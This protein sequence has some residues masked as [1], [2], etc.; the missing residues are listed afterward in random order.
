MSEDTEDR[1]PW[2]GLRRHIDSAGA[3]ELNYNEAD[4][5]LVNRH[6]YHYITTH[7]HMPAEEQTALRIPGYPFPS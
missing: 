7:L 1:N 5:T 3:K 4:V 2:R 6:D